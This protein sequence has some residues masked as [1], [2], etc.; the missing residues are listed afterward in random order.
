MRTR[1]PSVD[2]DKRYDMHYSSSFSTSLTAALLRW[3]RRSIWM[4]RHWP[5]LTWHPQALRTLRLTPNRARVTALTLALAMTLSLAACESFPGPFAAP[6]TTGAT[7][8]VGRAAGGAQTAPDIVHA[9]GESG[10]RVRPYYVL[11]QPEATGLKAVNDDGENVY[12]AFDILPPGEL[13]FFDAE[14]RPLRAV[15]SRN[16]AGLAGL[17]QGILVRLSTATSFISL[18][19]QA[20]QMR[21][22]PLAETPA[23]ADL[24][25]KLLQDV[26]RTAMARALEKA[27]RA[28]GAADGTATAD[29]VTLPGPSAQSGQSA[30]SAQAAAVGI[31]PATG[32]RRGGIIISSE[33]ARAAPELQAAE[34]QLAR[35]DMER[36]LERAQPRASGAASGLVSGSSATG[37]PAALA[38]H[39]SSGGI[40]SG[41]GFAAGV[42]TGVGVG[43]GAGMGVGNAVHSP[44]AAGAGAGASNV[45]AHDPSVGPWPRTQRV[46]FA[47]NSISISAPDDGL[48]RLLADARHADEVWIA[49]HTDATGPRAVNMLLARRRAEAI[50]YILTSRGIAP[51]RI[52]IV[53]APID[54][55]IA[56]NET[57]V[58]RSQNRRVEVT[59]VRSR[60]A[61]AAPRALLEAVPASVVGRTP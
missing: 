46:F 12:I 39:T 58:G 4:H 30:Q 33:P 40:G 27:G 6:N 13:R 53:R 61:A 50:K 9:N 5:K 32:R 52:V 21:K 22:A 28:A 42:A 43:T 17:H 60:S 23:L 8:P 1:S 3:C 48:H 54:T 20:D 31:D 2:G 36:A 34:H 14:G 55:Y 38:G 24:R 41:S 57:E 44:F 19:P 15:W 10:G 18:H 26:P 37:G 7:T 11:V 45:A 25:N 35:D 56:G 16:V 29:A 47:T 59:F 51:E 49:G